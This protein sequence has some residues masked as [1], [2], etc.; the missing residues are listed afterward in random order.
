VADL[1]AALVKQ[2]LHIPVPRRQAV[3][4]PDGVLDEGHREAVAGGPE[5]GHGGSGSPR[6]MMATQPVELLSCRCSSP[7]S[8]YPLLGVI[9]ALAAGT[10]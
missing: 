6:L 8:L 1:D 7:H 2:C 5:V 9:S 3:R 4:E 10:T